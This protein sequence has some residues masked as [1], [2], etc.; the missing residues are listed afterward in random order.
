MYLL[1]SRA[2]PARPPSTQLYVLRSV[3]QQPDFRVSA[4]VLVLTAKYHRTAGPFIVR[5]LPRLDCRLSLPLM[6][7]LCDWSTR[8]LTLQFLF[9]ARE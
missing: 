6:M 2:M 3:V 8:D 1:E 7:E 5:I 9:H 4:S